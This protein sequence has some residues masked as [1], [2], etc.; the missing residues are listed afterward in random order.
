[1]YMVNRILS[2]GRNIC[3][4]L[5]LDFVRF[6]YEY[7]SLSWYKGFYK[8]DRKLQSE[9]PHRSLGQLVFFSFRKFVRGWTISR[10]KWTL[11][12]WFIQATSVRFIAD[13]VE[14]IFLHNALFVLF[15]YSGLWNRKPSLGSFQPLQEENF[16]SNYGSFE[17]SYKRS[18]GV[19]YEFPETWLFYCPL[20][21]WR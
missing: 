3:T 7:N 21:F 18:T 6:L 20:R 12:S 1:M 16:G 4:T 17:M 5:D 15:I 13:C 14:W 8:A 19:Y 2:C 10:S 11:F 9:I